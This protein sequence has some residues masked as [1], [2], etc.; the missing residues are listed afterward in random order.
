MA[1]KA[2]I[3][4]A[5]EQAIGFSPEELSRYIDTELESSF[6]FVEE[7]FNRVLT[8][9]KAN[10]VSGT[11]EGYTVETTRDEEVIRLPRSGRSI[12]L[13]R[14]TVYVESPDAALNVF[15]ILDKGRKALP[16]KASGAYPMWSLR[17][18]SLTATERRR[19]PQTGRFAFSR[20]AG[21]A[22]GVRPAS[23]RSAL[24]GSYPS[25]ATE[26]PL[27][28]TKGPVKE[29]DPRNLYDRVLT[30][31][32][33]KMSNRSIRTIGLIKVPRG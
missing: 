14:M 5:L 22:G 12:R 30:N 4:N 23:Q 6:S 29:V 16:R 24:K 7:E 33:K 21:V 11:F 1:S 20:A 28:F 13:P 17:D 32:L 9:L 3:L 15:D 25:N 19:D 31:A 27:I 2:Q 26:R 10:S 8:E 18:V